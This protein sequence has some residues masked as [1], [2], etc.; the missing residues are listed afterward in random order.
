MSFE[1]D[2]VL[3]GV[4]LFAVGIAL[5][6]KLVPPN[7]LVG[8]CTPKTRSSRDVWYT[9]NRSA[10]INLVIAGLAIV[11]AV[12]AVPRLMPDYSEGAR[13]L[14]IGAI[15]LFVIGIMLTRILW[16]VLTKP[17]AV[18]HRLSVSISLTPPISDISLG[19]T[20]RREGPSSSILYG[21]K[22][23]R[24]TVAFLSLSSTSSV[25]SS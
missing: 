24:S 21:K 4:L 14:I 12:L 22:L 25:P 5:V 23:P 7:S 17:R 3:M 8:V 19:R 18:D 9:A 2:M 10:G 6:L 13:V 1:H 15:V 11:V 20:K 16:Q